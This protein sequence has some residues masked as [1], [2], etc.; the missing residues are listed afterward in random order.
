M[1]PVCS[2][3]T[4]GLLT[5]WEC[6]GC[7]AQGEAGHV[8]RPLWHH[9]PGG[10]AHPGRGGCHLL[11]GG[12]GCSGTECGPRWCVP[13]GAHKTHRRVSGPG[14]LA[15]LVKTC[16]L[17]LPLWASVSL[18]IKTRGIERESLRRFPS[19]L[20]WGLPGCLWRY[21]F[22]VVVFNCVFWAVLGLRGCSQ[23]VCSGREWGCT[24]LLC[25]GFGGGATLLDQRP[26][27]CPPATLAGRLLTPGPPG[28]PR[29]GIS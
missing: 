23:A 11:P 21:F 22:F 18:S 10:L 25:L 5:R 3:R 27:P 2:A 28:K 19:A 7:W 6:R 9:S 15:P 24:S 14:V 13:V 1:F 12:R 16:S 8:T 29:G 26:N 4:W 17:A 20:I